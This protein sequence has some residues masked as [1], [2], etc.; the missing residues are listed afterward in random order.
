MQ[1]A[2]QLYEE[3]WST[4]RVTLLENI[5]AEN[6]QQLDWVWQSERAQGD[7]MTGRKQ[8]KRGILAYRSAY[9]DMKWVCNQLVEQLTLPFGRL[10]ASCASS[11]ESS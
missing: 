11:L 3:V 5:M 7:P 2:R 9:P 8:M 4:G 10:C 1:R 6:H